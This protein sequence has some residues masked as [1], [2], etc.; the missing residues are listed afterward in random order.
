[1]EKAGFGPKTA[2]LEAEALPPS[3]RDGLGYRGSVISR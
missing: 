1:M 3:H 2:V